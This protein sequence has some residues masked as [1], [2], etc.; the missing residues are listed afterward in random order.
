MIKILS[1]NSRGFGHPSKIV[2]LRDLI[3]HKKPGIILL[4]E[5]KQGQ[6]EM[7]GIMEQQ[8]QFKGSINEARGASRVLENKEDKQ[9]III[10]NIYVPNHYRDKDCCWRDL[11][12]NIDEEGSSNIILG[13][14]LNLI[15]HAN[16]KRGGSFISDSYRIHLE[17]IM[18]EYELM[19]IVPKN[20]RYTWSNRRIGVGNIM[21]R[22]DK[23]LINV[24]LLSMFSVGYASVLTCPVSDHFPI[25]L[26]L[27]NHSN[28]GPIPFRYSSLWNDI[29]A[30]SEI[31]LS[32]W[33]QHVEGSPRFIWESKLKRTKQAIKEWAKTSYK[34]PEEEKKELKNNLNSTQRAI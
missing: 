9:T 8:K 23:I 32:T 27:E 2:A 5:T 18:Q 21:E 34:E 11:K 1:W 6:R 15:L 13:G 7:N 22:L 14:D 4:Q 16:E 17:N 20:R 3:H 29:P 31:V 30:V 26:M 10:Y 19:D 24:S 33:S 12:S 25:T 28:F